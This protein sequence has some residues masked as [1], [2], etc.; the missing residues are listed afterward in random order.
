MDAF[1]SLV[2]GAL[3]IEATWET[4]KP[5][6]QTGKLSV[7]RVA[8]LVLGLLLAYVMAWDILQ[9]AGLEP[10]RAIPFLGELFTA[11]LISRGSN[12]VHDL[13]KKVIEY[14]K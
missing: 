9:I 6:W 10:V 11:I 13:A 5:I 3:L 7:D 8:T 4:L 12:F 1:L 14:R 2:I